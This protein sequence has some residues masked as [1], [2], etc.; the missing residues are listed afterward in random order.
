[1]GERVAGVP[2]YV[3]YA[4]M[5]RGIV[6]AH[7]GRV[8]EARAH[9]L[10]AASVLGTM[11]SARATAL[12]ALSRIYRQ[13]GEDAAADDAAREAEGIAER[14]GAVRLAEQVRAVARRELVGAD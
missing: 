10:D 1:L 12:I 11:P 2:K 13:T 5:G 14:I 9:L 8:A 7:Q 6:L 3:A 4:R